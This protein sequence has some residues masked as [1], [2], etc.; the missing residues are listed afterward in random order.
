MMVSKFRDLL[1]IDRTDVRAC[2]PLAEPR[3][4]DRV[5]RLTSVIRVTGTIK[6]ARAARKTNVNGC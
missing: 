5:G 2:E 3:T 4:T 6:Y 1:R